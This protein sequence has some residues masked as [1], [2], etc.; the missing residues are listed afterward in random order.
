VGLVRALDHRLGVPGGSSSSASSDLRLL[1]YRITCF[2]L[3]FANNLLSISSSCVLAL[4]LYSAKT[5]P[6]GYSTRLTHYHRPKLQLSPLRRIL[7]HV[8][9]PLRNTQYER[10]VPGTSAHGDS[11]SLSSKTVQ[12]S[13]TDADD[14]SSL[15]DAGGEG[16]NT[17]SLGSMQAIDGLGV[18]CLPSGSASKHAKTTRDGVS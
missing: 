14:S 8:S 9:E 18:R 2:V 6:V 13:S 11:W 3:R 1:D 12:P 16:H 17:V 10:Y 7:R 5:C 15:S 4:A